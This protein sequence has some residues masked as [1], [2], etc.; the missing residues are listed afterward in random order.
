MDLDM[1]IDLRI[2][3]KTFNGSLKEVMQIDEGNLTDEFVRQPNTYAWFAALAEI[4]QALVENKKYDVSKKRAELD[5]IIRQR[6]AASGDKLTEAKL[7]AEIQQDKGYAVLAQE[8]LDLN[9][10]LGLIR[11]IVKALE[12]RSAMLIQLGSMRRQE[13]MMSDFGVDIGRIKN[14][15]GRG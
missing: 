14:A 15:Q 1:K 6:C 9:K 10:N 3:D 4:A 7:D 8:L 12:Q 13:M 11:A 2:E 5:T